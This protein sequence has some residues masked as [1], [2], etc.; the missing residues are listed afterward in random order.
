MAKQYINENQLKNI[1][2]EHVKG[3]LAE[4]F[5]G[6]DSFEFEAKKAK[7]KKYGKNDDV[8]K[9][10]GR[11]SD[12]SNENDEDSE[13][14]DSIESF[15][16]QPGVNCAA[17]AYKLYGVKASEGEDTDEMKNARSKFAKCLNHE[18]N[19]AG[20]P[21]S[22][23]SAE[24]NTLKGMISSNQLNERINKAINES[25]KNM[26]NKLNEGR[27]DESPI[28]KWV[29]WCFNYHY[30]QEWVPQLWGT[31]AMGDHMMKKFSFLYEKYGSNA[32][33]NRFFVE[34]DQENQQKLIDYVMNNY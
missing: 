6:N 13:L 32:V 19:E 10:D 15:F 4:E 24:L 23:T 1:I 21:Y 25:F 26:R 20:Y 14:R 28:T 30:P 3:Y 8:Y 27:Y 22:F 9:R 17:Y 18:K 5:F 33:M 31:G 12:M 11:L 34:L 29:Y 7:R 16:K 2:A